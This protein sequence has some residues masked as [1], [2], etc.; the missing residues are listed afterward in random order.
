MDSDQVKRLEARC[1]EEQPPACEVSCP[2]HVD[3]R[4]MLAK[5]KLGD[6]PGAF[7]LYS[8]VVPFPAILGHICDHP[9]EAGCRRAEA[10]GAVRISHIERTLVEETC[11]TLRRQAQ[12]IARPKRVT[13]VG[14]GLSG[15]TAAFDLAM[16]G[17]KVTVL[18]AD[19][20]PLERLHHDYEPHI[21]PPSAIALDLGSLAA[22]GVDIRC[23]SRVTGGEGSL[24]LA[25]LP[26]P[27]LRP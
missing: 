24:G 22:L 9:C 13:V 2:L 20:H 3:V 11:S 4:A 19:A 17:H 8:R 27:L 5:V 16:K 12:R 21:L 18:E 6:F 23:R 25:S 14:A 10:G 26:Q 7:A 15:L 1:I